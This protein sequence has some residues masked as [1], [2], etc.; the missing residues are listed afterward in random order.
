[1]PALPRLK[2]RR[3]EAALSQQDLATKASVSRPTIANLELG[4]SSARPS[5]V[6]KLALALDCR[7]RDLM[8]TAD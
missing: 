7:P 2:Q 5:T 4:R 1:M 8:G 6:R 3:E